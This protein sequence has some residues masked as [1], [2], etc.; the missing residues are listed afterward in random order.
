MPPPVPRSALAGD[1]GPLPAA[2]PEALV[3]PRSD[4][5]L[6]ITLYQRLPPTAAIEKKDAG[7]TNA[8]NAR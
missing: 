6:E 5:A 7:R 1:G 4:L 8:L 2:I 3:A